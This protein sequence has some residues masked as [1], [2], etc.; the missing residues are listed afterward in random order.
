MLAV[1]L[2]SAGYID[3]R[4]RKIPT[5]IILLLFIYALII[6]PVSLYERM[7]G[8][9]VGVVPMF[10]IGVMTNKIKGGDV[11]FIAAVGAA[12]GLNSLAAVLCFTS[13]YA[14][15]YSSVSKKKSVPLAFFVLLGWI[16]K[17]LIL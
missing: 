7:A 13:L 11:K 6:S 8:F 16:S 17:T 15:T 3:L 12:I 1:I 4:Y 9:I 2:I 14:V 5:V 10:C